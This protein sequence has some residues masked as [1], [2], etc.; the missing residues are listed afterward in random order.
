MIQDVIQMVLATFLP[1]LEL[2]FSIPYG[3]LILKENATLVFLVCTTANI[4]LGIILYPVIE[5]VIR[6]VTKIRLIDRFYSSYVKKI[7]KNIQKQWKTLCV[8]NSASGGMV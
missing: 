8:Y 5:W 1:F 3:I 4:L 7:Q 6:I 2:R